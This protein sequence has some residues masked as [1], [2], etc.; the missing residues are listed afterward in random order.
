MKKIIK[1][2]CM[3]FSIVMICIILFNL[4]YY[5]FYSILEYADESTL[6]PLDKN[7]EFSDDFKNKVRNLTN[8]FMIIKN[9]IDSSDNILPNFKKYSEILIND[10]QTLATISPEINQF[11]NNLRQITNHPDIKNNFDIFLKNLKAEINE[12]LNDSG[13]KNL[14]Q[15]TQDDILNLINNNPQKFPNFVKQETLNK[16]L[17]KLVAQDELNDIVYE[18]VDNRFIQL[19]ASI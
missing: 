16:E 14:F 2:N 17:S 3:F 1:N 19:G 18:L 15:I 12:N 13:D 8:D 6:D 9:I 4:Y 11:F 5:N 10:Y 7:I